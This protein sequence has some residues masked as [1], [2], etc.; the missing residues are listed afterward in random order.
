MSNRSSPSPAPD[1]A[2][3]LLSLMTA[4]RNASGEHDPFSTPTSTYSTPSG[5]LQSSRSNA[6]LQARRLA[7]RLSLGPYARDLEN[8]AAEDQQE[9][10]HLMYAKLLALEQ[11]IS[12]I[13]AAKGS[14]S[15][16]KALLVRLNP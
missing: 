4:G 14:Y 5:A 1:P 9:R 15:V 8:F 2:E 11:K 7:N 10:E 13:V 16:D 6:V 12:N 3:E